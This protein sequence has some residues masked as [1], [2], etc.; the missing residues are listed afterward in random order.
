MKKIVVLVVSALLI[1]G[2]VGTGTWAFFTDRQQ[3]N[4]NGLVAGTLDLKVN[5]ADNAVTTLNISG[6]V[7]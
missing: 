3:S 1:I 5:N 2:L 4:S 7:S 6:V